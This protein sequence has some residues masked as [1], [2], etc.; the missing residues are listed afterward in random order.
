[1]KQHLAVVVVILLVQ[2]GALFYV[3][4]K[5]EQ[6]LKLEPFVLNEMCYDGVKYLTNQAGGMTAKFTANAKLEL[7]PPADPPE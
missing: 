4:R 6:V 3:S 5:P 2:F 7:C 1:M